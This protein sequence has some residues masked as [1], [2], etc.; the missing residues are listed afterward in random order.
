VA[1]LDEEPNLE[2]AHTFIVKKVFKG[3]YVGGYIH[4]KDN[5]HWSFD[6]STDYLIYATRNNDSNNSLSI[7]ECS[8]TELFNNAIDDI[9]FLTN[10]I[11]CK[12]QPDRSIAA[13]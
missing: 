7:G 13:L 9:V 4:I 12:G 8:R 1:H 10:N 2:G 6:V 11:A 5:L 3:R